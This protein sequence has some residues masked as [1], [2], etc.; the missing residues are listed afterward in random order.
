MTIWFLSYEEYEGEPH[1]REI[2]TGL[3]AF[4]DSVE[5]VIRRSFLIRTD[6]DEH[7]L[8]ETIGPVFAGKTRF[9]FVRAEALHGSRIVG[10]AGK[11]TRMFIPDLPI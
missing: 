3:A 11:I 8:G 7:R 9:A 10:D 2:E 1:P 4:C 5:M 6:V